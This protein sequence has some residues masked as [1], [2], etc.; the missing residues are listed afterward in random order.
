MVFSAPNTPGEFGSVSASLVQSGA[1]DAASKQSFPPELLVI[2]RRQAEDLLLSDSDSQKGREALEFV[3]SVA[4][5]ISGNQKVERI[6][7][8]KLLSWITVWP[9]LVCLLIVQGHP[10]GPTEYHFRDVRYYFR[11]AN[12]SMENSENKIPFAE[13]F[14]RL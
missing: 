4:N 2:M 1:L 8:C 6:K 10:M 13:C 7:K 12:S 11:K 5:E 14:C 9:K 3:L